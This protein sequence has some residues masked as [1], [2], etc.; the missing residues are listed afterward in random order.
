MLQ[1]LTRE[2]QRIQFIGQFAQRVAR[3]GHPLAVPDVFGG[4]QRRT[5]GI[6]RAT[7]FAI[8]RCAEAKNPEGVC[9]ASAPAHVTG[10]TQ[11]LLRLVCRLR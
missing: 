8:G 6:E 3:C 10:D 2:R 5:G 9:L 1:M 7:K 11:P 4:G